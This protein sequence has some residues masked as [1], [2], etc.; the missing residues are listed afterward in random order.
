MGS[1]KT[2]VIL[3]NI[4]LGSNTAEKSAVAFVTDVLLNI[5]LSVT[6]LLPSCYAGIL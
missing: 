5:D 1:A 6:R 3:H 4:D 2:A